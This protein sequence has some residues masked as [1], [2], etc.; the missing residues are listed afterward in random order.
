MEAVMAMERDESAIEELYARTME[1]MVNLAIHENFERAAEDWTREYDSYFSLSGGDSS[2]IAKLMKFGLTAS[3][4]AIDAPD[5][6]TSAYKF[7]CIVE[8]LSHTHSRQMMCLRNWYWHRNWTMQMRIDWF[9]QQGIP[10][11]KNS[12]YAYLGQAKILVRKELF[13]Y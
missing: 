9:R 2:I 12:F 8:K 4:P 13:G 7:E 10:M 6:Q 11:N 3:A 5:W 1:A